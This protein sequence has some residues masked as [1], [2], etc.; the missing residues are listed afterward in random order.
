MCLT[1]LRARGRRRLGICSVRLP[2]ADR[3]ICIGGLERFGN[4]GAADFGE[5]PADGTHWSARD[6]QALRLSQTRGVSRIWRASGCSAPGRGL[7]ALQ[8]AGCSSKKWRD[9]VGL[10]LNPP[11][12]ELVLCVE[13][14]AH[15]QAFDRSQPL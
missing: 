15:T 3:G 7:R 13:E 8:K 5:H 14:K 1:F 12:K 6:G 10:Y 9:I 11:D 4:S 2:Y